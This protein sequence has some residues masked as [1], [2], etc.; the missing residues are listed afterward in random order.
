MRIT[1]KA[2]DEK[3]IVI[4]FP[5]VLL[6]NALTAAILTPVLKKH[7]PEQMRDMVS[8]SNLYRLAKEIR[9]AKRRLGDWKLLEAESKDGERVQ[10]K[11]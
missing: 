7:V 1:V 9:R 5:T 10:I 3:A 4:V 11:L 2:A 6:C 8:V